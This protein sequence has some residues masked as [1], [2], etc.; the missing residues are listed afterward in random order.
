[1]KQEVDN[2]SIKIDRIS[3]EMMKVIS[4]ILATEVKDESIKFVSITDCKVTND[5]S[6]AKVYYV[7]LDDSK[8]EEAKKAFKN[9]SGFIRK[10]LTDRMDIRH[11][12][13]LEFIYDESID[14]GKKIEQKIKEINEEA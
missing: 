8:K 1:M 12:P 3:S 5:L 4:Y 11:T 10:M 14:Y 9:A 7:L 2:M 13:E 6:F